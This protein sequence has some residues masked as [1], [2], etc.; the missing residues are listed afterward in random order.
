MHRIVWHESP[1][2][3]VLRR[4]SAGAPQILRKS[5]VGRRSIARLAE[6]PLGVSERFHCEAVLQT[7]RNDGRSDSG[8]SP[9]ACRGR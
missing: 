6:G 8:L 3:R 5:G 4:R 7:E 1:Q 9:W 2:V